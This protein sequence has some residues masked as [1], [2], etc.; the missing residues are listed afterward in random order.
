ML[1]LAH[2]DEWAGR[3]C[4]VSTPARVAADFVLASRPDAVM[5]GQRQ[6]ADEA[7]DAVHALGFVVYRCD[8]RGV[9]GLWSLCLD[10][11]ENTKIRVIGQSL[12]LGQIREIDVEAEGEDLIMTAWKA[13]AGIGEK[14][15]LKKIE[16]GEQPP[17]L[18]AHR[19]QRVRYW[20]MTGPRKPLRALGLH[21][22]ADRIEEG[23]RYA[24]RVD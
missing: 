14:K 12:L 9:D 16:A 18:D 7:A 4:H 11:P 24:N 1:T 10:T 13:V 17:D 2:G 3:G 19:L 23:S 22:L 8:G 20:K 15:A 6:G 5:M 21:Y